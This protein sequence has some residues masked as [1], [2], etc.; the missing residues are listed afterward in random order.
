VKIKISKK[1]WLEKRA[2]DI[3]DPSFEAIKERLKKLKTEKEREMTS[4]EWEE[5]V[6]NIDTEL[7]TEDLAEQRR[8]NEI[9]KDT[10][11]YI[12]EYRV[13][14][15]G[16][17]DRIETIRSTEVIGYENA[18]NKKDEID[19]LNDNDNILVYIEDEGDRGVLASEDNQ[20]AT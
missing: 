8:F 13:I 7:D 1:E 12:T 2:M 15:M 19:A 17:E 4:T 9:N 6:K 20:T 14:P 16:E 5:S 10:K 11:Y 3:I 18:E